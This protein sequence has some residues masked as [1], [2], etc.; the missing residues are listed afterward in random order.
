MK[1][2]EVKRK[3]KMRILIA[4]LGIAAL[5]VG[6]LTFA[7]YTSQDSVVNTFKASGN[8]KTT[9]VENFTPPSNWQP[10]TTT[11]KVVQI[12]NTGTVDAYTRVELVPSL[13]YYVA[14]GDEVNASVYDPSKTYVPASKEAIDT[15]ATTDGYVTVTSTTALEGNLAPLAGKITVPE[16]VTLYVKVSE[17]ES[18]TT[19]AIIVENGYNYE[20]VGY[21]TDPTDDTKVYAITVT[22]PT[23]DNNPEGSTS[24]VVHTVSNELSI[25]IQPTV[26]KEYDYTTAEGQ[27]AINKMVTLNFRAADGSDVSEPNADD[28][29]V[30]TVTSETD[31]KTTTYYYYK[32]VLES[33]SSTTALLNSVTFNKGFADVIYDA[34]FDLNVVNISTQAIYDAATD[35]FSTAESGVATGLEDSKFTSESVPFDKVDTVNADGTTSAN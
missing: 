19:D 21:L 10:G 31:A 6:G 17:G 5:I 20:F 32:H 11:D 9:I 34:Q 22:D 12:T 14:E 2:S 35:T 28:W 25:T 15:L 26:L 7:W 18:K 16:N 13:T 29:A 30:R 24:D 4:T 33:G 8:F 27:D 23:Y 1:R 3:K